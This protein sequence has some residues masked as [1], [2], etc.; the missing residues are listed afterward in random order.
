MRHGMQIIR[1]RAVGSGW[2]GCIALL[3]LLLSAWAEAGVPVISKQRV[4]D[5]TTR[6]FSVILTVSEPST[7]LLSLFAADCATPATGFS[8]VLQQN[9][10]SGNMRVTISG[11]NA[12]TGYC[13]QLAVTSSSSSELTTS[14]A[15]PVTTTTA[16]IRTA[17]SGTDIVPVGNDILK[18]PAV[19]LPAGETRDAIISTVELL[20]AT[21]V[22]P[23]SLL[24]SGNPNK[25]Y[26]N[27]NNLF[28]TATGKT[29]YLSGGERVKISE[30]HGISGCVIERFRTTPAA[31]GGT[32]PRTFVQANLNDIDA[33]GGVNILDVLRVVGGKGTNSVGP[34]FNSDLDLNG[35][36]IVDANDLTIIK[37][38]FNGLP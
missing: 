27:L 10:A 30:N 4:T 26:F 5:V 28:T 16:I 24:L 17:L 15:V 33:S 14:A 37:G 34:C 32:A 3:F 35:D 13:Y 22:S 2:T 7:V 38:G 31:S 1:K 36:G 9:P 29:L 12:A 19:H 11:L 21:A 20:N 18:V 6:S 25:D 8:T 23:L